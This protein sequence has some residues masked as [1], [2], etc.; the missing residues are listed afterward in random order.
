MNDQKTFD[1]LNEGKTL[2]IFQLESGGM[3]ELAKQLHIDR[4]EEI[5]AANALYRPG[6]M[7]MIPSFIARKHKKESIE[8]DHPL[9][10]DILKETYGIMV[11]QEQVMQIASKLAG[12]S[13]GEG[14]LL[15][16]AMGKKDKK[17]MSKQRKK[18]V[19][20]CIDHHIDEQIAIKV[21]DKIERFASYGFNKSHAAAYGYISYTTAFL[22]A[23]YPAEWMAAL[24]TCDYGDTSKVAKYIAECSK[25]D[26]AILPPSINNA[27][28]E[29]IATGEGIRFALSAI[30]GIGTGVVEMIVKNRKEKGSF[31]SLYDFL[32]RLDPKKIGRKTVELLV[33]VGAFDFTQWTRDELRLSASP[34]C[35]L[36]EQ[37]IKEQNAGIISMFAQIEAQGFEK[38]PLIEKPS[39]KLEILQKEKELMGFF[40]TGH[41]LEDYKKQL[42]HLEVKSLEEVNM[43][44]EG[45]FKT[46]FI[47]EEIKIKISNRTQRKFAILSISDNSVRSEIPIWPEMYEEVEG[48]LTEGNL[49]FAILSKAMKEGTMRTQ[50]LYLNVLDQVDAESVSVLAALHEKRSLKKKKTDVQQKEAI[51]MKLEIAVEME[52]ITLS[53]ILELKKLFRKYAGPNDVHLHYHLNEEKMATL[54]ITQP[55]GVDASKEFLDHLHKIKGVKKIEIVDSTLKV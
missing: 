4:F 48:L 5:M 49:L 55:W 18:F 26:I 12:Y 9:M 6:P 43:E 51:K 34:I 47:I 33:S 1:L 50:C 39:S 11:Y 52:Q 19:K 2:G 35:D 27:G 30:K 10:T 16:K 13:L 31:K 28:G 15:R 29:F 7:E 8:Q 25:L 38:K 20:G 23:H 37:K 44:T 54:E 53:T 36:V 14:D 40:L 45:I 41:P 42:Q 46:A 17:E 3:R 24:M 21:F 32:Y 22:K